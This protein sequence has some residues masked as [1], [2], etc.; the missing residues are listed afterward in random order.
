[1]E[2][3]DI[4][5]DIAERTGGDIYLGVVG[6]VRTGKSTFIRRFMDRNFHERERAKDELPQGGAGRTI[7]TTEPKFI[8]NEAVEISVSDQVKMKVRLVDCVGYAVEGAQG[9]LDE[10]GPRM[11]RTPW[12]DDPIPFEEAAEFGTRKVIEEHSTIGIVVTTDGSITDLPRANYENAESRVINELAELGKP[13]VIVVNSKNPSG[14]EATILAA[15]LSARYNVPA[16][17]MDCQNMEQQD[18]IGLLKEAL[19]MFPIRE[20]AIDLPRWVEELPNNHWL[21]TKFSNAVLEVIA[22]VNR[23]RDIEPAV[24]QLG[25]YDFIEQSILQSITPG[26]GLATIEL[27]CSHDLFYQ[28]L[29]ELSGFPIEG[30]HNLVGLISELSFAKR[31]YDKVADALRSVKETGY[32]LVSPGTDDIVFEQPELIRQGNRFGVKLTATAPSYHLIRA[33]ITAEVTPFVGT[34]KQ[35]EEFVRYLAEEFE[36]DPDQIWQ[37]DFLGK[38]MHDLVREGLQSKLTKMPENAQEKLQETLTKILNEGSG[39][40]ICIIL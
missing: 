28:V 13:Y 36:K 37:T 16:L 6:P 14:A 12:L 23:L 34:E 35:G 10:E 19:Y 1:M 15:E 9:F 40:L 33:N 4:L 38:S 7:M 17:P 11:V 22:D 2:R 26:E 39:G 5:K 21:Y 20:V 8:P 29:S 18:I 30:D 3:F 31:E 25:Q 24:L 32:G 27:S